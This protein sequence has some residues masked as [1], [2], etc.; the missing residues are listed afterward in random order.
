VNFLKF[1]HAFVF[2]ILKKWSRCGRNLV[3]LF[4]G[5]LSRKGSDFS[6]VV[7]GPFAL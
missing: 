5:G 6:A 4:G 7:D 1:H 2:F 3:F